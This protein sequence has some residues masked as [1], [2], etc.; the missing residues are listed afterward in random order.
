MRL[1]FRMGALDIITVAY[2]ANSSQ[3]EMRQFCIPC[4]PPM[5]LKFVDNES[6]TYIY[7]N[8]MVIVTK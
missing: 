2:V 7:E 4:A 5:A 3:L 8:L 6:V 1:I